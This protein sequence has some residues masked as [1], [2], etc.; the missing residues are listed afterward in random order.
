ML[1]F[2]I[3]LVLVGMKV[4]RDIRIICGVVVMGFDDGLNVS[5]V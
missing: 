1:V 2:F 4:G 3:E 5:S